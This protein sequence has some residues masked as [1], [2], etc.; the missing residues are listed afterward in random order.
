M[1]DNVIESL[2]LKVR[3]EASS[4]IANLGRLQTELR[5]TARSV[6]TLSA[7]VKQLNG[8]DAT[9]RK[10]GDINVGNLGAAITQLERLSKINL[11]NFSGKKINL[12]VSV[13]GASDAV[14]EIEATKKA[15]NGV[16]AKKY[17]DKIAKMFNIT[18]TSS[19]QTLRSQ[20]KN[21]LD[22]IAHD[23]ASKIDYSAIFKPLIEQGSVARGQFDQQ[24]SSMQGRYQEFLN[25]VNNNKHFISKSA[26]AE[27]NGAQ[28][29]FGDKIGRYFTTAKE[30]GV[31]LNSVWDELTSYQNGGFGDVFASVT[32]SNEMFASTLDN[33]IE[34]ATRLRDTILRVKEE[35]AAVP[36]SELSQEQ[37]NLALAHPVNDALSGMQKEYDQQFAKAMSDSIGKIPL[38]I[39]I[40]ESSI[41]RQIQRAIDSAKSKTYEFPIKINLG[42]QNLQY[43][44]ADALKG[45]DS[46]HLGDVG[47]RIQSMSTALMNMGNV[48]TKESGLNL[49]VTSLRKLASVD[50]SK[51]SSDALSGMV[52]AITQVASIGDVSTN[53]NRLV[54]SLTK[55]A[56]AG[57]MTRKSASWL[58]A[59]GE[60]IGRVSQSL[61][62]SGNISTELTAFVSAIG[63][64]ANAGNRTETT[65]SQLKNLGVGVRDFIVSLQNAPQVSDSMIKITQA[66]GTLAS[67]GSKAGSAAKGI[68][69]SLSTMGSGSQKAEARISAIASIMQDLC[70]VLQRAG[71]IARQA[72]SKIVSAFQAIKQSGNGLENAASSIRNLIG[73][74]VGFRGITGLAYLIKQTIQL[75]ANLTEIDHIVESVFGDM[76]GTVDQWAKDAITNFGIAEHSAKQYAG[77]LSSMFQASGIGYKNA[78]KMAMDLVGLA[79]D[80]SAFYNEDTAT[81]YEK[82]KSGMAGMVRPLRRQN[83]AYVQK[84]A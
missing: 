73:A 81:S 59:L 72:A 29:M 78:G 60:A 40:D 65:A 35:L 77:T 33:D 24:I 19:L 21:A 62:S 17:A 80:L 52:N 58:P 14:R 74:M 54:S 79:G 76:A 69:T 57:G 12:D 84:C 71:G 3:S 28:E 10:L 44:I 47:D 61:A 38:D 41:T 8:L 68:G 31:E 42:K 5:H 2:E 37:K 46:S 63:Q 27:M 13:T 20:F 16:D 64:L 48:N 49:F 18:D 50:M 23:D 56:S 36:I 9:F 55:L 66:L 30:K 70:N 43:Q 22:G 25:Y 39:L 11:D 32:K 51:F 4:A 83:C 15:I 26:F 7:S 75:G 45:L 34:Q 53:V 1:A 67:S 82:I 6:G